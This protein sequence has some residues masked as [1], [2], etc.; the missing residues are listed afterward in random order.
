MVISAQLGATATTSCDG[1][2]IR[3]IMANQGKTK[4]IAESD[5][6]FPFS[7]KP[8]QVELPLF[9]GTDPEQWLASTNDFFE[10]Y[11]IEDH[12]RVT[13]KSF[14]MEGTAKKWFHWI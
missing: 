8:V 7:P 3:E 5:V 10:F 11:S 9:N 12:H 1:E 14:K 4:M 6:V 13:V 2:D